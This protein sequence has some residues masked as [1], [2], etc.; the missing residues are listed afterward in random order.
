MKLAYFISFFDKLVNFLNSHISYIR[1]DIA[2]MRQNNIWISNKTDF[3]VFKFKNF[4]LPLFF[5]YIFEI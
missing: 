3:L 5:K 2:L 4:I 1:F